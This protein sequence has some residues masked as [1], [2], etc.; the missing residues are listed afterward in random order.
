MLSLANEGVSIP[1]RLAT[2]APSGCSV[3]SITLVSIPYRLA[4]NGLSLKTP[5][6]CGRFQFLIGWLQTK[7]SKESRQRKRR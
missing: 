3:L 6:F 1:Y 2:N 7:L 5:L 4:T